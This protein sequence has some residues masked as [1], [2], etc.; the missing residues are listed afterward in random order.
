VRWSPGEREARRNVS[1]TGLVFLLAYMSGLGLGLVYHPRYALYT[2][3]AVFYLHPPS[4]WWGAFLPD[5]RWSLVAG[6]VA[7]IASLRL[8]P[9]KSP[10]QWSGSTPARLLIVFTAW[11]WVQNL[12]ALAAPEHL[13]A[14]ILFTKY[15]LLFYLMFRLLESPE[16][17]RDVLI[18]HVIGCGYL[19]WLSYLAPDG[20]R[21]EG[22]G[23]PGIDE[24]NALGMFAGTGAICA[25]ML[26][27][28]ER[29]WRR[30]VCVL[31]MPFILNTIVQSESRGSML[32]LVAGGVVLFYLR[33]R[34]YRFM[35]YVYAAIGTGLFGYLAQDVF[36]DRM[37]TMRAGIDDQ[38]EID[39]SAESRVVLA[40]AQLLMFKSYPLGSGHRGTA[41]L[42]P[43]YLE[44][45]WL[46]A[47]PT[48]APAAR[49]S[50]S[51][52]MS[53]L[54]DQ[55][56][57][58]I[59]IFGALLVWLA[60][61]VK[62]LKKFTRTDSVAYGKVVLYGAAAAASL[63]LVFVAGMFTD[64]IKT[65]V[66]IWMFAI[67]ALVTMVQIPAAQGA[68]KAPSQVAEPAPALAAARRAPTRMQP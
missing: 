1:L 6:I 54:V 18:V 49:S 23:G 31:A 5:L 47:S 9:S 64:Y 20:G 32:G 48:G 35:F 44:E 60:R 61:T 17:V 25:S 10:V 24:A 4:R 65:E 45:K 3:L 37:N 26:I 16:E 46:S 14:S 36:W 42:S 13:E 8:P 58:G 67:L 19:G 21:L 50:H 53:A 34:G 29:T 28:T 59:I 27:L 7:L 12:W 56:V 38:A 66:Q 52:L 39:G 30:W 2:Y 68:T 57:P 15:L 55:G 22:V 62:S 43:K 40:K 51:T 41:E 11:L 33:P 63:T